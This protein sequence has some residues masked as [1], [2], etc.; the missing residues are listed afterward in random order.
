MYSNQSEQTRE[1][2]P[3]PPLPNEM[4]YQQPAARPPISRGRRIGM[5]LVFAGMIWLTFELLGS[6]LVWGESAQ[7]LS[8][9]S[10][11]AQIELDLGSAD[12]EVQ[13]GDQQDLQIE[14]TQYGRRSGDPLHVSQREGVLLVRNDASAGFLGLCLGN[15]GQTYHVT[16]PQGAHLTIKTSSGD[17]QLNDVQLVELFSSSG[18]ITAEH[19]TKGITAQSS[20]GSISLDSV[21]G[22]IRAQSSS[23]DIDISGVAGDLDV[24]STSG[25]IDVE[26]A[27][28]TGLQMQSSSGDISYTGALKGAN[29]IQ[30]S[31]GE[32]ELQ[33]PEDSGFVLEAKTG[34]G[35]IKN[36]FDVMGGAQSE[37]ALRG[38]I[39]DGSAKLDISTG[40]GDISLNQD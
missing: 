8:L 19:V 40:S 34:S 33:L 30:T 5:L 12:V 13:S 36:D 16:A 11:G 9:P 26:D 25:E 35:E 23:G 32:V 17:I 39:G 6:G 28:T 10:Q 15:C 1:H 2:M 3:E 7:R 31:S 21:G 14:V 4:Y 38:T 18:D 37:R 20:S 22:S 27:R 24:R 29:R